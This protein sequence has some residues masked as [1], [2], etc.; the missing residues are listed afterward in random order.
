MEQDYKIRE[1]S[2]IISNAVIASIIDWEETFPR[3]R[4]KLGDEAFIKCGMRSSL[5]III[6]IQ[7]YY[8]H[9]VMV[10]IY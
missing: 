2:S 7:L 6:Y 9:I 5:L 3:Q 4:P 10:Q 1:R 8:V